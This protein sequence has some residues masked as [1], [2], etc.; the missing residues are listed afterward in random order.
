MSG[1]G[2]PFVRCTPA[3]RPLHRCE[4]R[5]PPAKGG[6]QQ[7]SFCRQ[8]SSVTGAGLWRKGNVNGCLQ[9]PVQQQINLVQFHAK[10]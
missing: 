7:M 10:P 6:A 2:T 8:I 4:C 9:K 3:E 5:P 1:G